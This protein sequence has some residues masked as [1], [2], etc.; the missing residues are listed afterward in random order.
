MDNNAKR[1]GRLPLRLAY[2]F[3][4]RQGLGEQ[5]M[6]IRESAVDFLSYSSTVRRGKVIALLEAR[7]LMAKFLE[8]AW[9]L[10]KTVEGKREIG[11]C[12]RVYERWRTT[13][14]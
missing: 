12:R 14:T 13:A 9:P 6:A 11:K 7:E 5:A 10:G 8:Q 2:E 1:A 3:L 4:Q